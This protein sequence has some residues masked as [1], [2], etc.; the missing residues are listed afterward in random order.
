[1]RKL[2][3][4]LVALLVMP[5]AFATSVGTDIGVDIVTE[6]F[7]PLIWM[8]DDRVVVDDMVQ[9]GRIN[10]EP[11]YDKDRNLKGYSLCERTH[12]YAFE[13]EKLEYTVLVMDKNGINKIEDVYMTVGGTQGVGN[14]IEV[15]CVELLS[16]T[17]IDEKCNA[18]IDEEKLH[19]FDNQVM[20]YYE[21]TLVVEPNMY[22]E[23]WVTAEVTDLDGLS[24]TV[25]ENEFWFFN[26]VIGLDIDGTL[27]F[28]D[29]RPGTSSYSETLTV[30]NNADPGS[31]VML[32][33]FVTG[34]D[35]YDSGS[36]GAQCPTSN[37]LGLSNF[38]YFATNGAY[39]TATDA[40]TDNADLDAI[41]VRGTDLEGYVNIQHGNAFSTLLYNEAEIMQS[42][43]NVGGYW[44]ANI[45]SPG[46]EMSLTF[47]L[48]L[49]I[50]CNGDFDEGSIFFFGEAI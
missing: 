32:D 7:E 41:T 5:V 23:F 36:S 39:S 47:K 8:C 16:K 2:L 42:G 37:Q 18:R 50:P 21:C 48:N 44:I 1:M 24:N 17:G 26:P 28:S 12:N 38:R 45:L 22:G 34:T 46:G 4:I 20:R 31:G 30:E 43:L 19:H 10:C 6:D 29:V 35:F 49:P 9:Q 3:A 40:G 15:N 33:M 11:I 14:D 25:D 27:A 13:G